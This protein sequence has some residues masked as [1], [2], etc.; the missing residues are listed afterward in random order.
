MSILETKYLYLFI[1][2][3]TIAFPLMASFERKL[4]YVQYWPRLA[5]SAMAMALIFIPWDVWFTM[6][7]VWW[8]NEN[9]TLGIRFLNLPI[10][11]WL[12]FYFVPFACIFIYEVL[13]YYFKR[14]L[15]G[16]IVQ[17][18]SMGVGIGLLV[19]AISNPDKL[20]TLVTC[21]S[22]ALAMFAAAW[23]KPSWLHKF[24][25]MYAVSW[26]PFIVVNGALT[27]LFTSQAVVNYNELEIIGLRI[28]TIPIEDS[29]YN[30]LMLLIVVWMYELL[31][32]RTPPLLNHKRT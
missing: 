32:K 23:F 22:T 30:L 9:Y 27:G 6:E 16:K 2:V 13:N 28:G 24:W 14:D 3:F 26:I 12:F 4:N 19:I 18:L 5:L 31:K 7:G 8:F 29:I 25:R 21:L 17:N 1:L 20:Y 10:E 11:E 15:L